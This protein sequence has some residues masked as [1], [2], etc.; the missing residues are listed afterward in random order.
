MMKVDFDSKEIL[1]SQY[2]D[3]T[4]EKLKALVEQHKLYDF[5]IKMEGWNCYP[6]TVNVPYIQTYGTAQAPESWD[7]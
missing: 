5:K 2:E 1:I 6:Y 3:I 4:Y 7:S